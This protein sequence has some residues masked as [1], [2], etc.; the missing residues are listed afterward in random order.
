M[1]R[2]RA[3]QRSNAYCFKSKALIGI[4]QMDNILSQGPEVL[5]AR[6]TAF[7]DFEST[8]IWQVHDHLAASMPIR[9]VPIPD[10]KPKA[11]PLVLSVKAFERKEGEDLLLW[12][13][14]V[15][16]AMNTAML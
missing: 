13:R 2:W 11:R 5:S 10:D 7:M 4:E 9:Y 6:L 16:M 14:E 3:Y 15:E 8:L 1:F 12:V